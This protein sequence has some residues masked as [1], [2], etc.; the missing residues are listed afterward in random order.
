MSNPKLLRENGIHL[1]RAQG[2]RAYSLLQQPGPKKFQL[3]KTE[4]VYKAQKFKVP[5][6]TI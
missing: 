2:L 1:T 5:R 6:F 3:F 4:L